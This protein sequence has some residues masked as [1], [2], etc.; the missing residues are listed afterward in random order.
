MS[1]F[2]LLFALA[3]VSLV[4]H[5]LS[6]LK[7]ISIV[8]LIASSALVLLHFSTPL[9]GF[10][11]SAAI[12]LFQV[13]LFTVISAVIISEDEHI[14][15]TQTLFITAASVLLLESST[16]LTFIISFEALSIISFVLVSNI[17]NAK[18]AEGAIKMFISG[19][20]ATA[21]IVLGLSMYLLEGHSLNALIDAKMSNFAIVGIWIIM[22]GLFYKLTIV[23]MH[24][25]AAD[26][27]AQIKPSLA[28]TLSGVVKTVVVVATF[29]I[30]SPFIL[31]NITL[32]MPI[33]ALLALV[34]M[35][36]GNFLALWQK[37]VGKILSYSSI[38]HA[39]YMLLAFVAIQSKYASTALLYMAVAYIFMQTS[40]FL[41][42]DKLSDGRGD[43][44][45][46][47]LK[48]L[49]SKDK[50]ASLI[51]SIELFSLAGIPLLA[52]FLGKA[53]LVYAVVDVNLIFL[54]L[55]T[56]LNSA[57]SVGYYAWI[58]KHIYFDKAEG[59]NKI[60]RVSNTALISQLILLSGTLY[61]GLFAYNIFEVAF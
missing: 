23:P 42:L 57:L 21:I 41:L 32:S 25:W 45:L 37:S 4:I 47:N 1:A 35:T 46:D 33:L 30:F 34:T 12:E 9:S 26:T 40:L 10:T 28:A 14:N 2:V 27:Y 39:G 15:I 3:I 7:S 22:M 24:S 58:I 44:S 50:F 13:L 51:F 18:Q 16:L 29:K 20:I 60:S 31:N 6:I 19:S 53:I 52:G 43:L 59:K 38:A 5:K 61:F 55:F 49:Y 48:G 36:L 8:T 54:A 56:L 11:S 17:K